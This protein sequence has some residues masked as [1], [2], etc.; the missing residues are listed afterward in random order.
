M[1]KI[2]TA[3]EYPA[4]LGI[5][6]A[7][8]RSEKKLSQS[9]LAKQLKMDQSSISR[10]E[11]GDAKPSESEIKRYLSCINTEGSLAYLKYLETPWCHIDRPSFS[12]PQLEILSIVEM[13][14]SKLEKFRQSH[15]L[16]G[17]LVAEMDMH[18]AS[19]DRAA[20]YLNLLSHDIAFVGEIAVGKTT[21]LCFVS[22][23]LLP[24]STGILD[25][26]VLE[27]GA[28]GITICEVK[29]QKGPAYGIMV[30][31]QPDSEVYRAAEELCESLW[32]RHSGSTECED[33]SK[34]VSREVDRALRNMAGLPRRRIKNEEG[35]RVTIDPALE[36]ANE[37]ESLS[38]F[39]SSFAE[40]LRLWERMTRTIW[41]SQASGISPLRWMQKTF[42]EINNG[43]R[44]D[45]ALPRLIDVVIP[46]DVLNEATFGL[47][48][49][50]TKGVDQ[51]AVRPDLEIRLRDPRTLTVLCTRF[52]EAPGS[53]M[54]RFLEHARDT[55]P[56]GI[57]KER[58]LLLVLPRPDEARAVKDDTGEMVESDDEGYELK[59]DQAEAT[60]S[61]IGM[62]DLPIKFF[63]ATTDS[64]DGLRGCL[65]DHI[66]EIRSGYSR[67]I[68]SVCGAI[69]R[70]MENHEVEAA[71]AAQNQVRKR[72]EIFCRQHKALPER[73]RFLHE[74]LV[75]AF[76]TLNARTIWATTRRSG[77]WYNL[78]VFFY[79]G[80]GAAAD[81]IL[82]TRSALHGLE[83]LVSNM[84]GDDDFESMHG[85][86]HELKENVE[87]WRSDFIENA[88]AIGE[89]T[90]RSDLVNDAA[91]WTKCEGRWGWGAGYRDDVAEMVEEWFEASERENL[92][93]SAER[94]IKSAWRKDVIKPLK[95]L[96]D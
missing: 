1:D 4:D 55:L 77:S 48:L 92:H 50:D 65:V 74:E 47:S 85:Y 36:L 34:G 81:A 38:E 43:R 95:R 54:Q 27:A 73:K 35:K 29:I 71:Q 75:K 40:R 96:I 83:V 63:N 28:G 90:F 76:R 57:F 39:Q 91:F 24:G 66:D 45:I 6:L 78:D 20:A 82:R 46:D 21:A 61:K 80:R 64:P 49:V 68:S 8:L 59:G 16:P 58:V 23:M 18:K 31:P 72:L 17:P 26:V 79:L 93:S 33:S 94:K 22:G 12:N 60:L 30:D 86:L 19:L 44:A 53:T 67:R 2:Q 87:E 41:H 62:G 89:E 25:K 56:E 84:L 37:C 42:V 7:K 70:M 11:K 14:L 52:N 5:Q 13:Y 10:M 15:D 69:D 32:A 88:R 3:G 51:T 9:D